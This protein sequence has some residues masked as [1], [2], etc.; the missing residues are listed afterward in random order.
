MRPIFAKSLLL[1]TSIVTSPF[2]LAQTGDAEIDPMDALFK[3]VEDSGALNLEGQTCYDYLAKKGWDD[4]FNQ[5]SDGSSY[6]VSV[7]VGN[8]AAPWESPNYAT[9]M[10]NGAIKA[11]LKTKSNLA[12]QLSKEITSKIMLEVVQN[13]S[14]GEKP[15]FTDPNSL[16]PVKNYEELGYL[17]KFGVL[18]NQQLDKAIDEETKAKVNEQA[19]SQAELQAAVQE[20]LNSETFQDAITAKSNSTIRGMKNV[21]TSFDSSKDGKTVAC[22]V[23]L[24]SEKLAAQVDA[25]TTG[26][27]SIL[28][29]Q[30]PGLPLI[31]YVGSEKTREGYTKLLGTY[32][33]FMVR[34][35]RGEVSI[36]SYAQEGIKGSN[37]EQMAF[38]GA[39]LRAERAII[40]LRQENIDVV[41]AKDVQEITTE[42]TDGMV[43]YYSEENNSSR[44]TASASGKLTG[45]TVLKRWKGLHLNG[46]PFMGVVVAWTPSGAEAAKAA[47]DTM[48]RAPQRTIENKSNPAVDV[49]V[50]AS[51]GDDEEDF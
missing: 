2:L 36:L 48:S 22:V 49:T 9:S 23:G 1:T 25:I 18:V 35:E 21:F 5:K 42:Y 13:Y 15:E 3:Q 30:K 14:E 6:F 44:E 20:V 47:K 29:N 16:E 28:K 43:D 46:K 38:Q 4:G 27:Y 8:V 50:E 45:S 40:Q 51:M 24:W 32:G 31:D 7:G 19:A 34:N 12:Q 33:T 41:Q 10:M 26:D 37:G 17:E 11:Q 39:K